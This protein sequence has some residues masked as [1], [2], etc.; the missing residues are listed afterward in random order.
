MTTTLKRSADRKVSNSLRPNGDARLG[1]S[2]GLP[3]G[4]LFSCPGATSVCEKVC[5]AGKL[6]QIYPSARKLLLHNWD[7]LRNA[8]IRT[9]INE[10]DGMLIDFEKECE[11]WNAP[12]LFRI[13]WDGDFF[14]STYIN[15]WQVVT[16]MHADVQFWA[17][18]RVADAARI[19]HD[20]P[21]VSIYFSG[22]SENLDTALTLRDEGIKIA[23]LGQTF[24]EAKASLGAISAMCP[25]QLGRVPLNGACVTCGLCIKG[26]HNITF[27]I[28]KK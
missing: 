21:N 22:D 2:F 14:N 10:L 7:I 9:M 19:L 15:A 1:N 6:E 3:S 24:G 18:T 17:Y 28:S 4:K 23:M 5:Y 20:Y 11:K 27:S 8:D 26:K 25:E 13:H 12:K 16:A